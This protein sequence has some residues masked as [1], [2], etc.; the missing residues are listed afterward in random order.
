MAH[1]PSFPG[2]SETLSAG[3]LVLQACDDIDSL[4]AVCRAY[5][6]LEKFVAPQRTNDTE[7]VCPNRTQLGALMELVNDALHRGIETT[8]VTLQSLRTVLSEGSSR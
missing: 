5:A 2:S 8:D 7:E 3:S 4:R 6:C 1:A